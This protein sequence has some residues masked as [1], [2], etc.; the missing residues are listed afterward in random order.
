M[1][2]G[3]IAVSVAQAV[4]IGGIPVSMKCAALLQDSQ[5]ASHSVT[6]TMSRE[7]SHELLITEF[8]Q[9]RCDADAIGI[10]GTSAIPADTVAEDAGRIAASY[11]PGRRCRCS[12]KAVTL[13]TS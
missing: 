9:S 7:R 13:M 1:L 10:A 3:V 2:G 11:R 8:A 12:S 6:S 4:D 5:Y